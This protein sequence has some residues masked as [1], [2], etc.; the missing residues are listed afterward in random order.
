MVGIIMVTKPVGVQPPAQR[1]K[2]T[3][4]VSPSAKTSNSPDITVDWKTYTNTTYG[5]SFEYPKNWSISEKA[6]NYGDARKYVINLNFSNDSATNE[7]YLVEVFNSSSKTA[8]QFID[9]WYGGLEGGPSNIT[10]DTINNLPV[11]KF[12]MEKASMSGPAGSA[13]ILFNK[14]SII[15]DVSTSLRQGNYNETMNDKILNQIA[16][17]FQFTQ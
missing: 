9:S 8:R 3:I 6:E 2:K 10:D 17:T 5:F 13:N 16:S 11:V 1:Q 12:F 14:N 4:T 7:S 15:V